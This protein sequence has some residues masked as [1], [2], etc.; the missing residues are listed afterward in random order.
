[1]LPQACQISDKDG[2]MLTKLIELE[3]VEGP[4]IDEAMLMVFTMPVL[5]LLL[6]CFSCSA[7]AA[8]DG[9]ARFS[10]ANGVTPNGIIMAMFKRAMSKSHNFRIFLSQ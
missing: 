6:E 10:D 1:M 4:D 5:S 3:E 9:M 8:K 7:R 2:T